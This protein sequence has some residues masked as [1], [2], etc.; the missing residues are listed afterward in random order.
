MI[1][2]PTVLLEARVEHLDLWASRITQL[3][4]VPVAQNLGIKAFNTG[5]A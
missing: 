3:D 4:V 2:V 1:R 5:I